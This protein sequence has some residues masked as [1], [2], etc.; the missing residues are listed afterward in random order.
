MEMD[1]ARERGIEYEIAYWKN[2]LTQQ[3]F[4]NMEEQEIDAEIARYLPQTGI[5]QIKILDV[6]CGPTCTI[7]G[8]YRGQR[9]EIV[10]IDPLSDA[11]GRLL[12]ELHINQPYRTL[13]GFGEE[14]QQHFENNT[15][16]LV[17]SK[18]A[19]DH[20]QKPYDAIKSMVAVCKEN[21]CVVF[22]VFTNEALNANYVGF[23]QWN[24][25]EIGGSLLW[26]NP[27]QAFILDE[28]VEGLPYSIRFERLPKS[29]RKFP[30]RLTCAIHKLSER[31]EMWHQIV[32]GLYVTYNGHKQYISFTRTAAFQSE[33][34]FFIHFI[35]HGKRVHKI[36]FPWN[37]SQRYKSF[38]LPDICADTITLGQYAI[39]KESGINTTS[40]FWEKSFSLTPQSLVR[41]L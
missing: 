20:S 41:L 35:R 15:F 10:G 16:D 32:D 4:V 13:T 29:T 34:R 2:K 31:L 39:A 30:V 26:W 27:S 6:G 9:L 19:L 25:S 11:Y 40:R 1:S 14:L 5:E 7:G 8:R 37:L 24:F 38:M 22:S 36:S 17:F 33:E 18:N 23:H 28:C 21:A 12:K 3:G